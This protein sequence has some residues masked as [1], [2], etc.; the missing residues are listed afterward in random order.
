MSATKQ[1]VVN[2]L[3]NLTG[4]I[5][6]GLQVGTVVVPIVI[7]AVKDIKAWLDSQETISFTVALDTGSQDIAAGMQSFKDSLAAIN[8]ELKADGKPEIPDPT[9]TS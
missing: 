6:I 2:T 1:A 5:S 8:A 3:N 7:G 4:D 9:T